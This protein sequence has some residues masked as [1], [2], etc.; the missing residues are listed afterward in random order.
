MPTTP[1]CLLQ[2][3]YWPI[4]WRALPL[5]LF[6]GSTL[7]AGPKHSTSVP[8]IVGSAVPLSVD[9]KKGPFV[10]NPA[11]G[12]AV[13]AFPQTAMDVALCTRMHSMLPAT[14][15]IVTPF[16][17]AETEQLKVK[18]SPGQVGGAAVNCPATSPRVKYRW[19][20]LQLRIIHLN[21]KCHFMSGQKHYSKLSIQKNKVAWI[22]CIW[23]FKILSSTSNFRE[24]VIHVP[25]S[26]H[27][28]SGHTIITAHMYVSNST[29]KISDDF[30]SQ[31]GM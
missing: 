24:Y 22:T 11:S 5:I 23:V 30:T 31:P 29:P 14:L 4:I 27:C 6:A 2:K 19:I 10:P 17:L 21:G 26:P 3:I 25:S 7:L 15:Q 12:L 28:L 13:N 20:Q 8:F 16:M 1:A 9:E 18:V